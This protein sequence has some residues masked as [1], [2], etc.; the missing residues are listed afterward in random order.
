METYKRHGFASHVIDVQ[1]DI[2][3]V[4]ADEQKLHSGSSTDWWGDIWSLMSGYKNII[5]RRYLAD[6]H[7]ICR[8]YTPKLLNAVQEYFFGDW[9]QKQKT[10]DGVI[11]PEWWRRLSWMSYYDAALCWGSAIGD[12]KSLKQLA[13]YPDERCGRDT[14]DGPVA[15]WRLLIDISRHLRGEE[16]SSAAKAV[17]KLTGAKW[18]GTAVLAEA[19]DGI[20]AADAP[21]AEEALNRFFALHHKRKKTHDVTDSVSFPGTFMLNLA[22][23]RKLNV[24]LEPKLQLYHAQL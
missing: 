4:R 12:W 13:K 5:T 6:D 7:A 14:L 11:D 16:V 18:R 23:Y 9:K 1:R 21:A 17:S 19:L 24:T 15:R 8:E 10:G 2:D 20:N 22:R 3:F